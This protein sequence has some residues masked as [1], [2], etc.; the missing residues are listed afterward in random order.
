MLVGKVD[1]CLN[2]FNAK[3]ILL[4]MFGNFRAV[5]DGIMKMLIRSCFL[6]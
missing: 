6:V 4:K 1:V 2:Q 3:S 5:F